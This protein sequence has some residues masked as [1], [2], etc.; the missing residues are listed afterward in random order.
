MLIFIW[1]GLCQCTP[2]TQCCQFNTFMWD[3][4]V[5]TGYACVFQTL[6]IVPIRALVYVLVDCS[7]NMCMHADRLGSSKLQEVSQRTACLGG[8]WGQSRFRCRQK[9]TR[10]PPP[11]SSTLRVNDNRSLIVLLSLLSPRAVL[12][13]INHS[14]CWY[15]LWLQVIAH[16]Y[17]YLPLSVGWVLI[18]VWY[19][20]TSD[21]GWLDT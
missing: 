15:Q 4:E 7:V 13:T 3:W 11:E 6:H 20:L 2:P 9:W 10:T 12:K 17:K 21:N 19:Q 1:Y 8:P 16:N 14:E 18:W 5:H